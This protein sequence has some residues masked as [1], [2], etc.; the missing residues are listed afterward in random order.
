[1][2]YGKQYVLCCR[3]KVIERDRKGKEVFIPRYLEASDGKR[4]HKEVLRKSAFAS[5]L[6]LKPLMPEK[7]S[8]GLRPA[9]S[10]FRTRKSRF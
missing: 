5:R 1:M 8:Y 2:T 10:R 9:S 6:I 4:Y 3:G 7:A